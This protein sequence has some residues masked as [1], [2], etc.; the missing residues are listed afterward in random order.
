M[1]EIA[2]RG[3]RE[4]STR[5]ESTW[6]LFGKP[7][8]P[9][10][11]H[12]HLPGPLCACRSDPAEITSLFAAIRGDEYGGVARKPS[13]RLELSGELAGEEER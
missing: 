13:D 9:P 1:I 12:N 11:S 6:L 4:S 8:R 2:F 5:S 7:R 3:T 10:T